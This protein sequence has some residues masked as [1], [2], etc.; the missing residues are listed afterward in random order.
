MRSAGAC[1]DGS[2]TVTWIRVWY[3]DA[4]TR[5]APPACSAA[6]ATSSE[7]TIRTRVSTW[8]KPSARQ[9]SPTARRAV[10]AERSC[11][12]ANSSRSHLLCRR[13]ADIAS[14]TVG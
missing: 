4:V 6:L 9:K 5:I 13:A 7:V 12:G 2:A 14:S 3:A 10:D 1:G 11:G 8:G